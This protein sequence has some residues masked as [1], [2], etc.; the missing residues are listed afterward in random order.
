M[1]HVATRLLIP[2]ISKRSGTRESSGF[3]DD[4]VKSDNPELWDRIKKLHP[5]NADQNDSLIDYTARIRVIGVLDTVNG[6]NAL[7][8][9]NL[10]ESYFM[11]HLFLSVLVEW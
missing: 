4:T 2:R 11:H 10:T 1:K 3:A 9:Q 8:Q 7:M 6:F 5:D